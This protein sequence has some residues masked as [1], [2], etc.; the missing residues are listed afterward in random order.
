MLVSIIV[1]CNNKKKIIEKI[2]NKK[3]KIKIKKEIL[4]IDDGSY[5]G[6]VEILKK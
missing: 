3:N 2:I 4:I 1:P 5:D 6:T